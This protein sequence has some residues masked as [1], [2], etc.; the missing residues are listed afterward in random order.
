M[1]EYTFTIVLTGYG[2]N[3]DEA[4]RDAV[5][6]TDLDSDPTPDDFTEESEESEDNY[7][8]IAGNFTFNNFTPEEL[9]LFKT[10]NSRKALCH[11]VEHIERCRNLDETYNIGNMYDSYVTIPLYK[12]ELIFENKEYRDKSI[13]EVINLL[14]VKYS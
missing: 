14:F 13:E 12:G 4:W 8:V 6:A 7:L 9:S 11:D 3:P 10:D 1:K 2:D 5:D